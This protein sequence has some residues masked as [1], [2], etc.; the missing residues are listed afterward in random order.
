MKKLW[1]LLLA[2]SRTVLLAILGVVS[3]AA[4]M[5]YKL[6]TLLPGLSPAEVT[7]YQQAQ[8]I[9]VITDNMVNAPY[10][11][12]VFLSTHVFDSIFGLRLAGAGV[13]IVAILVFYLITT[14]IF[15]GYIAVA[16]TAM[17]A[18]STL[19]L[20]MTR[21]ATENVML[22]SLFAI[23]ASGFYVRFGKRKDIGWIL[24]AGVLGLSLYVP[25][26]ILFILPALLWQVRHAKKT[27]ERLEAPII[28]AS[29]VL[30]GMLLIPLLVSLVREPSLWRGYIGLP[31]EIASITEM[32]RYSG[33]AISSL[34]AVSPI[35]S[36]YW[37]GRQPILDVFATTMFVVGGYQL[38]RQYKLDRLWVIG[39]II[40]LGII[41]TGVTTNR[42]GVLMVLPFVYLVVGIGLQHLI[43]TWFA[44]FPRNPIARYTGAV[45]LAVA[46]CA[47]I[48]FQSHRFFVAWPNNDATKQTFVEAYPGT[49]Q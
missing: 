5:L 36:N 6:A 15:K 29:A 10:K 37:L 13:G 44:V 25:G 31:A 20:V 34:F 39:G 21:T 49:R 42:Y 28:I 27:L 11:L 30:F 8:S 32:L 22:L 35:D 12:A 2:M 24:A 43:N 33:A 19:L 17:F 38:I 26:M 14:R 47:S 4:L 46:I 18:T 16:T 48:N 3:V 45:L 7:T 23:I 40:L 1:N 41:W 9:G